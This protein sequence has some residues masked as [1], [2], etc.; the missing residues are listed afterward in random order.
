MR[1]FSLVALQMLVRVFDHDNDRVHHR[2]DGDRDSAQRHNIR[3]NPLAE[4]HQKGN[5]HR[6]R[7][8][9]NRDECAAQVHAGT[10]GK[11]APPRCFPQAISPQEFLRRA[12]IRALRSY[13]TVDLNVCTEALSLPAQVSS[14]RRE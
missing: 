12:Q 10:P 7:Q 11:P 6:H 4:H 9:Q 13:A 2:A 3:A 1:L 14:S 8:N 5:E